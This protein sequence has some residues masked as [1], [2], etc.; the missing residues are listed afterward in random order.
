MQFWE[1]IPSHVSQDHMLLLQMTVLLSDI[2]LDVLKMK[3]E[4]Y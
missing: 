4:H 1:D 3:C 2:S